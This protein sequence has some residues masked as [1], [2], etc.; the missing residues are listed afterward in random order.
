MDDVSLWVSP[1]VLVSGVG[2]L[3]LS[4]SARYGQIHAELRELMR[5]THDSTFTGDSVDVLYGHLRTRTRLLLSAL[6]GLYLS[7]GLLITGSLV[8][9]LSTIGSFSRVP[10]IVL[11]CAGILGVVYAA[12]QLIRES[13]IF[14][15]TV[16]VCVH[17][18]VSPPSGTD[19]AT[20]ETGP[21]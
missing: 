6:F 4:T 16:D 15:H 12:L 9:V 13:R 3:I 11:T 5:D 7:V 21:R 20:S 1:V 19:G 8:G 2:L 14:L 18:V 17:R 10:V